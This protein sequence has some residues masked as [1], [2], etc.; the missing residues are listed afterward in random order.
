MESCNRSRIT[1]DRL[2]NALALLA[3]HIQRHVDERGSSPF[4]CIFERLEAEKAKL[5]REALV[6]QRAQA[7]LAQRATRS[8]QSSRVSKVDPAP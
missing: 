2:D 1:T 8:S 3:M 7:F 4:L 6:L 5:E